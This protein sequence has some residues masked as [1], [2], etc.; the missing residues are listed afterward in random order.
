MPKQDPT[1]LKVFVEPAP[2]APLAPEPL[3]P[4][5]IPLDTVCAAFSAATSWPLAFSLAPPPSSIDTTKSSPR[6]G[7]ILEWSAPVDPGDGTAP[8]HLKIGHDGYGPT[9]S[10]PKMS[11]PEVARTLADSDLTRGDATAAMQL[12][13]LLAHLL[14]ELSDMRTA[15]RRNRAELAVLE[16]ASSKSANSTR[17]AE[18]G[19]RLEAVLRGGV[20]A[21]DCQAAAV[22]LLNEETT[23]LRMRAEWGMPR[24]RIVDSTRP[25]EGSTAD[26]EAM[27]GSA[28]V[29]SDDTLFDLWHMPEP[30]YGAAVCVP[31][32]TQSTVL[33]TF[34]IFSQQPR[35]F[36]DR[37]TNLIEIL[38]G[39]VA[40]ELE[41]EALLRDSRR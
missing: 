29:L 8:G 1:N 10:T 32:A 20:D 25:L 23:L 2:Q 18:L 19:E 38:A 16:T 30:E 21:L 35:D 28:V 5:A 9:Q 34:W 17:S 6:H 15:L 14:N 39:R 7:Q 22:Y 41:H 4:T 12:A 13:N 36:E 33:G 27:L 31:I 24:S 11:T 3:S 26:L 37:D 40:M